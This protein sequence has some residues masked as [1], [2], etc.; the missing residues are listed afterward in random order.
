MLERIATSRETTIVFESPQRL[1]ALLEALAAVCGGSRPVAVARE[2]TKIHEEI[3]R[4]TIDEI[5]GYYRERPPRG[6]VTV[7]TAPVD[8]AD[9]GEVPIEEA[10]AL[11]AE[12]VAGGMK[13][14]AAARELVRRLDLARTRAY[15]IVHDLEGTT[16]DE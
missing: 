5:A 11:A 9:G 6:E 1:V 13:P 14:S 7:V 8:D 16:K 3:R 15:R 10:S 4:G 2:L 12:L